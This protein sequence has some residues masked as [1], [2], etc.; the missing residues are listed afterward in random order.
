[1]SVSRPISITAGRRKTIL[2]SHAGRWRA[3]LISSCIFRY[4]EAASVCKTCNTDTHLAEDK[5]SQKYTEILPHAK[6]IFGWMEFYVMTN[7][8]VTGGSVWFHGVFTTSWVMCHSLFLIG[9]HLSQQLFSSLTGVW[10]IL[11]QRPECRTFMGKVSAR[12]VA[13]SC[14]M[15]NLTFYYE[16]VLYFSYSIALSCLFRTG[17]YSRVC[18]FIPCFWLVSY[19]HT[20][21]HEWVVICFCLTLELALGGC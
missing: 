7:C 9:V 13:L 12:H 19:P 8:T 17:Y 18:V 21:Q 16:G 2:S 3:T 15:L 5:G 4:S 1:M 20:C 6:L 10:R 14:N 11:V